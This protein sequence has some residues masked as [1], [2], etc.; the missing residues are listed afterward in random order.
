[1]QE[2]RFRTRWCFEII[3][4]S[5]SK[6]TSQID[7]ESESA[8]GFDDGKSV[9]LEAEED[10]EEDFADEIEETENHDVNEEIEQGVPQPNKLVNTSPLSEWEIPVRPIVSILT[11]K[12]LILAEY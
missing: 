11:Q 8:G 6:S 7:S 10:V 3:Q 12:S 4:A 1:M 9:E 5:E 2:S